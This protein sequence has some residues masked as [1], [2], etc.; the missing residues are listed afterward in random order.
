MSADTLWIEKCPDNL[1]FSPSL[2]VCDWTR[3]PQASTRT[4]EVVKNRPVLFKTR[5]QFLSRQRVIDNAI[6][7]EQSF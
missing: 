1:L 5:N 3:D 6:P 7:Q 4:T 2:E